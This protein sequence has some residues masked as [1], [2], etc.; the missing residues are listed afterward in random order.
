[1]KNTIF[2]LLASIMLFGC[3]DNK[4]KLHV[5]SWSDYFDPE[6][7]QRFEQDNDCNVV[8]DTFDS[9]EAM[10]AKLKAGGTGYDVMTPSS[11]QIEALVKER[12]IVPLDHELLPTVMKNFNHDL[13][14]Q[15]LDVNLEWSVPYACTYTGMMCYSNA[16]G[17]INSWSAIADPKF[18]GKISLLDDLRETIGIGLMYNGYSLNSTDEKEIMAAASTIVKWRSNVR[19]FDAESYKL[20]VANKSTYIGHGYSSDAAQVIISDNRND[21]IFVLPDEG[22]TIA[23]DEFVISSNSKQ[24]ELAYK[25]IDFFYDDEVAYQNMI[26]IWSLMANKKAFDRIDDNCKYILLPKNIDKGQLLKGFKDQKTMELYNKAW[27]LIKSLDK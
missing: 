13:D 8:I 11:Y 21:I 17:S 19:K 25:F 12:M 26:Y 9:N 15:I 24:L 5:Y 18:K 4:P 20:E 23:W 7:I 14:H 27:D 3:S 16:V 22:F 6:L 10:Y 1:M 2:A